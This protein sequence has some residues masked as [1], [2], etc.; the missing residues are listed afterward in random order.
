MALDV[1]LDPDRVPAAL[2]AVD[3]ARLHRLG[4]ASP[5][6]HLA[7]VVEDPHDVA[8][9]DGPR[10]GVTGVDL[11]ETVTA[12]VD[13]LQPRQVDELRV[14]AELGVGRQEDERVLLEQRVRR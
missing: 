12:V 4:E 5:H 13:L 1:V 14:G 10:G 8:V 6:L 3:D 11:Q 2:V 9:G 7:P